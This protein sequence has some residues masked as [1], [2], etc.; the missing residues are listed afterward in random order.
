MNMNTLRK[1]F[2]SKYDKS[3]F[4]RYKKAQFVFVFSVSVAFALICL[5]IFALITM[6]QMRVHEIAKSASLLFASC[7]FVIVLIKTGKMEYAANVLAFTACLI[8]A[9]GFIDRPFYV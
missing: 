6:D 7:V 9:K 2:F 3:D 4:V 8:A 5:M 1:F